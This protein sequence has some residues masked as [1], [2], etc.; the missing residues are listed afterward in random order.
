MTVWLP[1]TCPTDPL[2]VCKIGAAAVTSI[3]VTVGDVAA[4]GGYYI[5]MGCQKI[6]AEPGTLTGSIGVIGGKLTYGGLYDTLGIK[7]EVIRRGRPAWSSDI[8]CTPT[9]SAIL[10][11]SHRMACISARL[12]FMTGH[13]PVVK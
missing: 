13:W 2:S 10:I 11:R 6:Y 3:H 7:T 8:T 5:S 4:S 1:T 9:T 12:Y